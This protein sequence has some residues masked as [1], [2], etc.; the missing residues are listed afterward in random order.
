MKQPRFP[1]RVGKLDPK[2]LKFDLFLEPI[3]I[4]VNL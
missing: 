4:G 2:N 1:K 3:Y